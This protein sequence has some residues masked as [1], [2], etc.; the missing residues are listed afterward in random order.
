MIPSSHH[1]GMMTHDTSV[2]DDNNVLFQSQTVHDVDVTKGMMCPLEPGQASLHHGWTLHRSMPNK[3]DDR[4]IGLN[5]QYIAPHVRQTKQPGYSA[6]LVRGQD[7]HG[8]YGQ[9]QPATCEFDAAAL[10]RN[11]AMNKLHRAITANA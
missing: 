1:P 7:I 9:E 11:E 8:H 2:R 10:A 3:S 6:L 4:R 5:I